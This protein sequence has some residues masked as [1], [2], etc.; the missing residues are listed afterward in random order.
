VLHDGPSTVALCN[1]FSRRGTP[2]RP[3]PRQ[4]VSVQYQLR[5]YLAHN[6]KSLVPSRITSAEF[7]LL[8]LAVVREDPLLPVRILEV[9]DVQGWVVTVD[10][11]RISVRDNGPGLPDSTIQGVMDFTVRVSSREAYCSPT[12]GAQ[13]NA[14]KTL[15][16]M[17]FVLDPQHGQLV[18]TTGGVEHGIACRLDPVSQRVMFDVKK[19]LVSSHGK[20][21]RFYKLGTTVRV[22]WSEK[23]GETGEIKWPFDESHPIDKHRD[24]L[25]ALARGYSLFNPHLTLTLDWFG[26]RTR[27][28]ATDPGWRK[29]KP[30]WPTSPHWYEL[31]HL[32]R[33]VGAYVADGRER[34]T[35][36]TVADFLR[37][38]DGLTGSRKRT[39]VLDQVDLKRVHLSDLVTDRRMRSDVIGRLLSAMKANT[40]PVTPRRLG[41][42]GRDHFTKRLIEFGCLEE[43]IQYRVRKRC[44]D[45]IAF[46]LE[47]AFGYLDG[48]S[49]RQIYAG[50]NWSAG[51]KNPFRTFG[52][53]GE[54]LESVLIHQRAGRTEPIV[55]AIHLAHPRVEYTDRGKSAIAV[56]D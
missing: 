8:G 25:A 54:G 36:R 31:P 42:I 50:A 6:V 47:S 51:I 40:V 56:R 13:G 34:G 33:L 32:E 19:T 28:K 14:L 10:D 4:F 20:G 52:T 17:P 24:Q 1:S 45:G 27:F 48:D 5:N 11:R 18:I 12:R 35:D 29:W 38:F 22:E 49:W 23:R 26:K 46:V 41:Q 55:F 21:V 2:A 16:G 15:V 53:T 9:P 7:R 39:A 30:S 3:K 44:D 43:S 37:E